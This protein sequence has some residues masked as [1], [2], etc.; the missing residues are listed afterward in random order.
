MGML[1]VLG[2]MWVIT[3]IIHN[4]KQP[5][6][7]E[8]FDVTRALQKIDTPSILFFLGILLAVS[9]LQE[10]GLLKQFSAIFSSTFRNDYVVG[11]LLGLFSSIVDNVPLVAAS[12]GMYSLTTYPTDHTFWQFLALTTGTGGSLIIIGSAAGVAVMGIERIDFFLYLKKISWLAL[13]GFV[14]GVL[15]YILQKYIIQLPALAFL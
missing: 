15:A 3:A 14:A 5:Q 11:V 2:L 12:Q 7:A 6:A 4:E 13:A 1:L 9:A 10:S 8:R